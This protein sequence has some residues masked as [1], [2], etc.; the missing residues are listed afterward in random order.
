MKIRDLKKEPHGPFSRISALVEWEDS[1]RP[2][3]EVFYETREPL[4]REFELDPNAFLTA[5]ALPAMRHG[6]RRIS[7]EGP[8]C[9]RLVEGLSEVV[10]I[11]RA[12][13]GPPRADIRVEPARGFRAPFPRPRARSGLFLTGGVDSLHLL[14]RNRV[15]YPRSHP[16]S[17]QTAIAVFGL[18]LPGR[19]STASLEHYSS[20][21]AALADVAADADLELMPIATNARQLDPDLTFLARE[22]IGAILSSSAHPF[23]GALSSIS[24][25]SGRNVRLLVP[26]GTH[27]LI[28][29]RFSTSALEVRHVG[30]QF[31][32][33]DR[34]RE[35]CR[36]NTAVRN[37]VVCL[38]APPPKLNCGRCE[39]CLRTM[40]ALEAFGRL[41]DA[42]QFP[43]SE[44]SAAMIEP[45][46]VTPH[47][48]DYWFDL[49]EL[50]RQA[51][52]GDLAAVIRRKLTEASETKKWIADSGW[53]GRLR[54]L[55]RTILRGKIAAIRRGRP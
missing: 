30:I 18:F 37:L 21:L 47:V 8:V 31:K 48:A 9:P 29:P 44:V 51:D 17:F 20:T 49:L 50:L 46:P 53:K 22:F 25:A 54:R 1:P 13:F 32:R 33:I 19:V 16:E 35:I 24:L 39:K 14:R 2:P 11:F 27:P 4:D 15:D 7:L 55:D 41:R 6:E 34:L 12:W 40:T 42:R 23:S 5:C 52:R 28:D 36:W 26:V 38:Q 10:R 3:L 43:F 45:I